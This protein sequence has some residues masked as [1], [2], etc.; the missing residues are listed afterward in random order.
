[1]GQDQA[2]LAARFGITVRRDGYNLFV[3]GPP[4]VGKQS[5]LRQLLGNRAAEELPG[6]DWCYVHNF[7]DPHRPHALALPAGRAAALRADMDAAVTELQV[8]VRAAL[9]GEEYRARRRKLVRGLEERQDKAFRAAEQQAKQVG[10]GI[11]REQDLFTVTP[12]RDGKVILPEEFDELPESERTGRKAELVRA[13]DGLEGLL[14]EFNDWGREHREALEALDRGTASGIG[15]RVFGDLRSK[16]AD[17]PAVLEHLAAVEADLADSVEEFMQEEEAAAT[18]APP[19][20][21]QTADAG[22]SSSFALR[23]SINVLTDHAQAEGAPVVYE[24]HPTYANLMGRIEHASQFGSLVADFTLIR[25]GALHRALGGYLLLDAARLLENP[26][27]WQALVRTLRSGQICLESS[28]QQPDA[29]PIASLAPEPI[30]FKDTKVIL[31]GEGELYELLAE[32]DPDFLELFKVLVDFDDR[33]DRSTES[34]VRFANLLAWLAYKDGLHD[35]T[36]SGVARVLDHAAR[37]SED[38]AKLSVRMRPILDLM[39]EADAHAALANARMVTAAHVEQAIEAQER[40]SGRL[41]ARMLEDIRHGVILID[42]TGSRVGQVNGLSVIKSGEHAF[43]QTLRITARAWVGKGEVVDIERDVEL[44]G[45]LH[46]K[47][48]LIC[49]GLLGAR[50]ATERPLSLSASLV[51]EQ[52]YANV[53]GDSASVAE[54]CALLSA[55]SELPVLQSIAITGSLNQQGDVQAIGGVNEKIEGF[56]DICFD[57]GLTGGQGVAIPQGNVR[58]LMLSAR[59]TA[60]VS[61]GTFHVWALDSLDDALEL[62]MGKAAGRRDERGQYPEGSINRAVHTRLERFAEASRQSARGGD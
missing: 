56:F 10:V 38:A 39:R 43:G 32:E 23:A 61:A 7:D 17:Q 48:V 45:P 12:L 5:V 22:E 16:Y 19:R 46:S 40:R 49:R 2:I 15:A 50:Y 36:R 54:A 52:S 1:V 3:V 41:R 53:D 11:V 6:E 24:D 31:L 27:A 57:R 33:M 44:G 25:P 20:R 58:H 37:L 9:E 51:F 55:L 8:A 62:L 14:R 29:M 21:G 47:G 35:F 4:G 34:E 59:V 30:A 60:A 13:E 42:S 26:Q 18:E 28:S